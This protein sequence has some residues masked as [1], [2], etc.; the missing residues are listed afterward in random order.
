M[1]QSYEEIPQKSPSV[2]ILRGTSK[3]ELLT[4]MFISLS[5]ICTMKLIQPVSSWYDA[6]GDP[7]VGANAQ[8]L[9]PAEHNPET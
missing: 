1:I 3:E 5:Q 8:A 6:I 4:Q 2:V 7:T 9:S